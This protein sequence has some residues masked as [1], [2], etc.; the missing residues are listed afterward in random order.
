MPFAGGRGAA[1]KIHNPQF[2][3]GTIQRINANH[4][5]TYRH[6]VGGGDN[7]TLELQGKIWKVTHNELK[8]IS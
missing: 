7:L 2:M 4:V 1:A 5:K 3:L 8:W 6:F